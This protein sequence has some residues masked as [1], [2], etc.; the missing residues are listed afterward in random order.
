MGLGETL[1]FVVGI[2][3]LITINIPFRSRS[4]CTFR[5]INFEHLESI[6]DYS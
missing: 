1:K 2:G 4:L 6:H 5:A 3:A